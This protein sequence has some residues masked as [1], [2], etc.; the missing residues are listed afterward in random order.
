[1]R[2]G[3]KGSPVDVPV[4]RKR[5]CKGDSLEWVGGADMAAY[6]CK[7]QDVQYMQTDFGQRDLTIER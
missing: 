7:K 1:M 3:V 5:S 6:F 4:P 2:Q